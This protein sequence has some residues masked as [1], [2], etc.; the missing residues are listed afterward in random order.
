MLRTLLSSLILILTI[1]PILQNG[2]YG[3]NSELGVLLKRLDQSISKRKY[4]ESQKLKRISMLKK[5]LTE[6]QTTN[7][8]FDLTRHL[9][10]E[11]ASY[12]YD[13][14]H[15]YA[16]KL[17]RIARQSGNADHIVEGQCDVVFCLLSAGLFNEASDT[18]DAIDISGTTTKGKIKYYQTASRLYYDM[19][20]YCHAEPYQQMYFRKGEVYTDSLLLYIKPHT[21][22]WLYAVGMKYMKDRKYG[23]CIRMFNKLLAIPGL[24][25]HT[26][27]IVTSSL[28]W[29][30]ASF[31]NDAQR[32]MEYLAM[33]AVYDNENATKET[34]ALRVLASWLYKQGDI[35]RAT[36]YVRLSLADANFYG[37]R[38]RMIEVSEILPIIEQ[39][40]YKIVSRQ[41]NVMAAAMAIAVMFVIAL[42]IGLHY[43]RIQVLKLRQA[44]KIVAERN[45]QLEKINAQLS[46][47]NKIKDVYIGKSFYINSEYI[48]KVEKLYRTL[49]RKIAARQFSD[50]RSSLKE[51]EL[52]CDRKLMYADFDE[53]FLKLFPTFIEQYNLLFDPENR[54]EPE[55]PKTLTTEMRI[56][57]LIR[58]G[59]NDSEKIAKFLHYSVNTI[60]TYKTRV[61]NKSWVSNETFEK[62]IMEIS[63]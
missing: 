9:F 1:T 57:A 61:K 16:N 41:R 15:T 5:Q 29:V 55:T 30:V 38:Q 45:L 6:P 20:D 46:E 32:A 51:S 43:I 27:A 56:F 35:R 59:I 24:D 3:T 48:N 52:V 23:A 2:C 26:K 7:K 54:R 8:A 44:R 60:N 11:Y 17:I 25:R 19:G 62:K 12:Q 31:Q 50:L 36:N 14:A 53:T 13:S 49:D 22:Q 37:A 47:A 33:A 63:E 10:D 42:A 34:T 4:Y 18:F 28:G 40:H 21:A 39:D 58:I